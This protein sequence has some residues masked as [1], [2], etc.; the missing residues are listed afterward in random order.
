MERNDVRDELT[1]EK[2]MSRERDAISVEEPFRRSESRGHLGSVL[3]HHAPEE[4]TAVMKRQAGLTVSRYP[5]LPAVKLATGELRSV[6]RRY[7]VI[8]HQAVPTTALCLSERLEVSALIEFG[9][10][11]RR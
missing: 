2:E 7:T 5:A 8:S 9:C 4:P 11:P 1:G 10:A 6:G 3:P